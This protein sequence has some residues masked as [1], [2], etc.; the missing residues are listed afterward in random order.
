MNRSAKFQQIVRGVNEVTWARQCYASPH[1]ILPCSLQS[2]CLPPSALALKVLDVPLTVKMRTGVQE[3]V[4]L[5]H[6]LLPELRDWGVALVTVGVRASGVT[7]WGYCSS[8]CLSFCLSFW[9][10]AVSL[11]P[12]L[13]FTSRAPCPVTLHLC[14]SLLPP[15]PSFMAVP[16]SSA[17]PD[18]PTGST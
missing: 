15:I 17:T 2:C 6:R 3:R 10:L 7:S 8:P 11:C 16:G 9:F 18:W 4:S 12:L 5:A 13:P 1:L 14:P